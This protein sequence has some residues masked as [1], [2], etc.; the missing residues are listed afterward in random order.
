MFEPCVLAPSNKPA[1]IWTLMNHQTWSLNL[2]QTKLR[3]RASRSGAMATWRSFWPPRFD[4]DNMQCGLRIW[5]D[6][7]YLNIKFQSTSKP[8]TAQNGCLVKMRRRNWRKE[9]KITVKARIGHRRHLG[10]NKPQDETTPFQLAAWGGHVHVCQWLLL[11]KAWNWVGL[12]CCHRPL[13]RLSLGSSRRIDS[14]VV[15]CELHL[16]NPVLLV[17][18]DK[19]IE[20]Q[21]CVFF[22]ARI[23]LECKVQ[24]NLNH[25]NSWYC[26][27]HHFA[28]LAGAVLKRVWRSSWKGVCFKRMF[29][30][31][32]SHWF[33][34]MTECCKWLQEQRVDL[35][36]T[37]NQG[38]K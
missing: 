5:F 23:L 10:C 33:E 17:E 12:I 16:W 31:R 11:Q 38:Q 9:P 19:A 13:K 6:R 22:V 24:A 26:L 35:G 1:S 7:G 32:W 21:K 27:A 34:G 37:N 14:T 4:V 8:R 18:S 29:P 2:I 20:D 25:R 28:A 30:N 15:L 36:A 3:A